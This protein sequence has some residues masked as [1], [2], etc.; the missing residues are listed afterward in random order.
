MLKKKILIGLSAFSFLLFAFSI[1]TVDEG[2]VGIVKRFGEAVEQVGPGIHLKIPLVHSI[3]HLEVRTRKNEEKMLSS[4]SEQMPV[5]A[6]VSVNWTVSKESAFD[7]YRKYGGLTQ[8]ESRILDP[9]FKSATKSALPQFTAEQLIQN[10]STAVS[11][12]EENLVRE[13]SDFPMVSVD[14]LQIEN[15]ILP[16][17]YIQS[18]ET[19]QT[20]KNLAAA[21]EHKLAR[22]A[23]EAQRAVNTAKANAES[24]ELK[25][26]AD[27]NAIRIKGEAEAIAIRAKA[28]ALKGNPLIVDLA[29]I[30]RWSGVMPVT[31]LGN[32]PSLLM[33]LK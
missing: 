5:T 17:K 26:V 3:V 9:R 20:E 22:Q 8:F 27:A 6:K 33:T 30:E 28:S 7:L 16:P 24:I 13:M 10:R 14:S 32:D 21:E 23:L 31:M 19:K 18:I 11:L 25:A 12:I 4:T 2:N 29:R 15:I 1:Y